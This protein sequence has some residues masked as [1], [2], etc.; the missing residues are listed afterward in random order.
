M[1]YLVDQ[2]YSNFYFLEGGAI[3]VLKE[4]EYR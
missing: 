3:S 2:D 4:Q 1:Y